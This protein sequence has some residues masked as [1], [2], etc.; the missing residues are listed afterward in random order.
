M[1]EAKHIFDMRTHK[2]RF[3]C[4]QCAVQLTS[5]P[6]WN[7]RWT[8]GMA[9][10]EG[11]DPFAYAKKQYAKRA[12][13]AIPKKTMTQAWFD[14]LYEMTNR[15]DETMH[16]SGVHTDIFAGFLMLREYILGAQR[17]DKEKEGENDGRA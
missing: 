2:T 7:C 6:C 16:E 17:M 13:D 4:P 5:T 3:R 8:K 9:V 15:L 11:G 1:A 12:D 10:R 14:R